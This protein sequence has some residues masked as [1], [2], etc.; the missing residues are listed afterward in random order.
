MGYAEKIAPEG[1]IVL[2]DTTVNACDLCDPSST[3]L[4][5][6]DDERTK[7]I[8]EHLKTFREQDPK[9]AAEWGNYVFYKKKT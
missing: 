3:P 9:E 4:F 1:G 2:K 5:M 7:L 6:I 8:A